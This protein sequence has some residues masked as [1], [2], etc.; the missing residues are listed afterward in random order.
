[1]FSFIWL[2]LLNTSS[3]LYILTDTSD[4]LAQLLK[5]AEEDN[6]NEKHNKNDITL[7][8]ASPKQIYW[9][10]RKFAELKHRHRRS[11]NINGNPKNFASYDHNELRLVS[12][13]F[14]SYN[15]EVRPVINNTDV[16]QVVFGMAYT[17]LIDLDEKN[18]VLVSNVWVRMSWFNHLLKWNTKDYGDIESI[19]IDPKL[20]WLPDIVLY[21]NAEEGI[22]SGQM[23]QFKTKVILKHN[24]MNKWYSPTILRSYCSINV[25]YFPFDDQKCELT[26]LSWTYDGYR[27]NITNSD[28]TAD[29][30]S[31]TASGEFKLLSAKADHKVVTYSCCAEP[32]PQVTFAIHISRKTLFYFNNLIVPCFFITALS[33]LTFVLP[34]ATGERVTL[35]ITTLLAMT[36]FMLMI[37]EKTPTTSKSTPLIG[38]FF[39]TSVVTIG[40]SLIATCI[41]LNLYE[42]TRAID[43]VPTIIRILMIDY[44]SPLLRVDPPRSRLIPLP[45]STFTHINDEEEDEGTWNFHR[46]CSFIRKKSLKLREKFVVRVPKKFSEGIFVLGKRTRQQNKHEFVNKEWKALAKIADRVFLILFLCVLAV[47]TFYIFP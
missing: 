4:D 15:R 8:L 35:V 12:Y 2:Y 19:N 33:L 32:Y 14:E 13:L 23:D 10:G 20:I 45:P 22:G 7:P 16:V 17:Q 1:M 38:K 30:N 25:E 43:S 47:T 39:I 40:L 34:P 36:V 9:S 18:Q 42:C 11:I 26:F 6:R 44:L 46:T 21:N 29:T 3:F 41:V 37:A 5:E 24:G 31:Y 28:V 27:V